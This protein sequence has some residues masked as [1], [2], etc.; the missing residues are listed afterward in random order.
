MKNSNHV[1]E[2]IKRNYQGYVWADDCK[3]YIWAESSNTSIKVADS[4]TPITLKEDVTVVKEVSKKPNGCMDIAHSILDSK[5]NCQVNYGFNLITITYSIH[6][7]VIKDVCE[8]YGLTPLTTS[9]LSNSM[10]KTVLI[11]KT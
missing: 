9:I 1:N 8:E 3:D 6:D 2:D 10:I 7:I 11:L 4:K 5:H